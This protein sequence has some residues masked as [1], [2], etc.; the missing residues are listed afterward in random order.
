MDPNSMVFMVVVGGAIGAVLGVILTGE[1]FG[2]LLNAI[3]GALGA[4]FGGHVLS[5]TQIDMGPI[6]NVM[7]AAAVVSIMTA[8]VLKT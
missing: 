5:L 8:M 7:M 3:A 1:G 4:V 2:W 6:V